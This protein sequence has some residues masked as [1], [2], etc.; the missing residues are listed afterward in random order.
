METDIIITLNEI[1]PEKLVVSTT[2]QAKWLRRYHL[3]QLNT[4]I[5][6]SSVCICTRLRLS[7]DMAAQRKI[8][9]FQQ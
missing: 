6:C 4:V 8:V 1:K 2:K 7:A 5:V 3:Y 9:L